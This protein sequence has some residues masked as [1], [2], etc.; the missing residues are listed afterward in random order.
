MCV[1]LGGG[2][3]LCTVHVHSDVVYVYGCVV[4]C[5]TCV[6]GVLGG[7]LLCTVHVLL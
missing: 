3:L 4:F 6:C 2:G 1:V 7:L 5:S